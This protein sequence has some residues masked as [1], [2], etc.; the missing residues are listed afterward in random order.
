MATLADLS[1]TTLGMLGSSFSGDAA[2]ALRALA[3]D[4]A[5]RVVCT[6]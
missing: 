3:G 1:P 6:G 2:G 5:D 4:Y